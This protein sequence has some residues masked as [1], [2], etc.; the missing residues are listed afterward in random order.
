MAS[1][2]SSAIKRKNVDTPD[3]E[4]DQ[5]HHHRFKITLR[6]SPRTAEQSINGLAASAHPIDSLQ[7]QPLFEHCKKVKQQVSENDN[8]Q[9]PQRT[10]IADTQSNQTL[11]LS[12]NQTNANPSTPSTEQT[13]D[14]NRNRQN[15]SSSSIETQ[16][17]AAPSSLPENEFIN[18][19]L[20]GE[21]G[22]G[23]S[24]F[25]NAF[26]NYLTF[27]TLEEAAS[28]EP[29]ALIPVSFL[30]TIGDDFTEQIV[31]LD[32]SDTSNNEDFTHPG[33]SVTQHCRSYVFPLKDHDG[34]KLRIIDTPGFGDTRGLNQDDLNMQHILE[35]IDQ[36][37]HLNAVC[38]LLKP[39]ESR[40]NIFFR[41]CLTQLFDF[42]GS[43]VRENIIFCFTNSRPTF[44]APGDTGPL[45]RAMLK[46]IP[47]ANIS[48]QKENAY[49]F[50]S[51]SF[52]YLVALKNG[53]TFN[54]EEKCEYETSWLKSVAEF[55]R[56]LN[57]IRQ[58]PIVYHI[59]DH[60]KSIKHA[61][62]EIAHMIRPILEAMRN[63]LRNKILQIMN[64][65]KRSIVMNPKSI[66]HP[67]TKCL[68]YNHDRYQIANFWFIKECQDNIKQNN[69]NCSST[70]NQYMTLDY[71]L[72][73][74]ISSD[75]LPINTD[76]V[77]NQVSLLTD[78]SAMFSNFLI[79]N[80][81]APK[82]D[83]FLAGLNWMLDEERYIYTQEKH[84]SLNKQLSEDLQEL[85]HKYTNRLN[86]VQKNK[87]HTEPS[88]IHNL[89]KIIRDIPEIHKQLAAIN[90]TQDNTIEPCKHEIPNDRSNAS[91]L[92]P[93]CF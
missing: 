45:L 67:V 6:L 26:I 61:Q 81:V 16:A 93:M 18:I 90:R 2:S 33:Q 46:S 82:T 62:L 39:N 65:Q 17:Y 57:H 3:P 77:P 9:T 15:L 49:C 64:L 51:E 56:L 86:E 36:F 7:R 91:I 83:L 31:K 76:D 80:A 24:T 5:A 42:L 79:H 43:N 54:N 10:A 87:K 12:E 30:M 84:A 74:D 20:L 55:N 75:G 14:E 73:Y 32:V 38:F 29:L 41:T 25:I 92:D 52:R 58:S 70:S 40:L 23:K 22:V 35:Y 11:I 8:D 28:K 27:K 4:A 37:T 44:Y 50:D 72:D 66:R 48:F 59:Q 21:T 53:I 69:H 47:G 60:L 85:I 1:E 13:N 63:H 78:A 68:L 34:K 88:A 19:L 71:V 89:I